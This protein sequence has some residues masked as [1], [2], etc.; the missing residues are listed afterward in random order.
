MRPLALLSLLLFGI[1]PPALAARPVTIAQLEQLL[2]ADHGKSDA[3]LAGQLA[4]LQLTERAS[5][6]RLARWQSDDPGPRTREA[7]LELADASS[8]L[9]LPASDVSP[10]APPDRDAERQML[11]RTIDYASK[12]IRAL[13]NF[14]ATRETIHFEDTPPKELVAQGGAVGS[15]SVVRSMRSA[16]VTTQ[17]TE[18]QPLHSTGKSIAAVAY[19]DGREVEEVSK[20]KARKSEP[21]IGLTTS[22][23]FGPILAVVLA[24]AVR[25]R[26][27]WAYWEQGANG[28]TAVFRYQVAPEKSHY[29]V[30][31]PH[32]PDLVRTYPAYSGEIAID[33]ATGSVLRL[34][35]VSDLAPPFQMIDAA[36]LVDYAPV[37]IG[38]RTYICPVRGV[39]LSKMPVSGSSQ[40]SSP[41]LQ[42]RLNDVAFTQYH[43]FRADARIV[44]ADEENPAAPESSAAP[45]EPESPAVAENQP[46]AS[47]ATAPASADQP[48]TA[49]TTE[50][51][52]P[53]PANAPRTVLHANANLVL[54]NVVVTDHDHPVHGLE[55]SRF[56][57]F[58]DGHKQAIT[59]F[60]EHQPA[61]AAAPAPVALPPGTYTNIPVYP[62][63]APL[64]VLLLDGLNTP[65]AGQQEVRR[66][67]L[68]YLAKIPTGTPLALFTLSSRL[69]MIAG[70]TTD[71]AHLAD[72]LQKAESQPSIVLNS[73]NGAS[74]EASAAHLANS[75]GSDPATLAEVAIMLQFAADLKVYET[76]QRVSLTLDALDRLARYLNAIPG[77][78]NLIWFSGSF[79]IALGTNMEVQQPDPLKNLRTYA[80]ATRET[81]GLLAAARVAV[82]PVDARGLMPLPTS[83]ASY[84]ASAN[85]MQGSG[86]A[87]VSKPD[88]APDNA[89]FAM[90]SSLDHGSMNQIADETGGRAFLDTN[91]LADAVQ[92]VVENGSS[93]Y[94]IGYAPSDKRLD[95]AFRTIDVRLDHS[96]YKLAYRRGYYADNPDKPSP[97]TLGGTSPLSA[98][99]LLGA[100]PSTQILF[101]ARVLPATDPALH[102][103]NL[104][105]ALAA[106]TS[107][108][109]TEPAH[110]CVVD[111]SID[112]RTLVFTEAPNGA[113]QLQFQSAVIA[114]DAD[115]QRIGSVN[116]DL[117]LNVPAEQYTRLMSEEKAPGIPIRLVLDLLRGSITL[118]VVVDDPAANR[119]GSLE[120]PVAVPN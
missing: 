15:G 30:E 117:Q 79:P 8:F 72:A 12:T 89:N 65:M 9:D 27:E 55:Q 40:A 109:F 64:N 57:I 50:S 46:A 61:P 39:A 118:R 71:V 120:I 38:E 28:L 37:V 113:R 67:M 81:S 69:Q 110:R 7:L 59:S 80:E 29:L 58:E 94:T 99:T 90:Q 60:E 104:E 66:Q 96:G 49:P 35:L 70:F 33:P 31:F 51:L 85:I 116:R 16:S 19:R 23:E 21:P 106:E 26:M 13:P 73:Q 44:A 74:L 62:A 36:I 77:R 2:L 98:A 20:A 111:L 6:A 119:V 56:H 93:Y 84:V 10:N 14:M 32:G 53:F 34:T 3:K 47:R 76:D 107:T 54:L 83:E 75:D 95:A 102:G 45:S 17:E 42:T 115:G 100:P 1:L 108:A 11:S 5:A 114:Y 101:E 22:G 63:G 97:H 41:P 91:G 43:L 24:D 105:S 52:P 4:D 112:P 92:K 25:S 103:V 82:Y 68:Q 86:G 88:L 18:Y 48:E 78:K 87:Q